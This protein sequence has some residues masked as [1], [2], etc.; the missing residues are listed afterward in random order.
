M[1]GCASI[2]IS[3]INISAAVSGNDTNITQMI[4][5]AGSLTSVQYAAM[6]AANYVI[7]GTTGN[8]FT[9]STNVTGGVVPL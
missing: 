4:L 9:L 3:R 8:Q 6:I 2:E 7:P 1:K 5:T